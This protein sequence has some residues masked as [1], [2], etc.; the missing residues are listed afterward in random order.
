MTDPAAAIPGSSP[1]GRTATGWAPYPLRPGPDPAA[2][3]AIAPDPGLA[4]DSATEPPPPA[5]RARALAPSPRIGIWE[6]GPALPATPAVPAIAAAGLTP[7]G[8]WPPTIRAWPDPAVAAGVAPDPAGMP[9]A[10]ATP[11]PARA[12]AAAPQPAV[13]TEVT[14]TTL[15]AV[16][17][18][19]S[20]KRGSTRYRSSPRPPRQ[21]MR[22]AAPRIRPPRPASPQPLA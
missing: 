6:P 9:G 14:A 2:V 12:R 16:A 3:R 5:G 15:P 21:L 7:T 19:W 1:A 13:L 17:A 18:A 11:G 4:Y 22:P 20:R 8:W 10:I